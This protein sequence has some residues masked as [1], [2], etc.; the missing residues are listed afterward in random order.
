MLNVDPVDSATGSADDGP[1]VLLDV[2]RRV[3]WL[4]LAANDRTKYSEYSS[5][6]SYI[7]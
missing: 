5:V 6:I 3:N 1:S 7:Q 4:C 2:A